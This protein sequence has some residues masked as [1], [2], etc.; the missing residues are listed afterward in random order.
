MLQKSIAYFQ[1][2]IIKRLSEPNK[3]SFWTA[4]CWTFLIFYLSF[5]VPSGVP[6]F[7][8]PYAD[9]I[10]HFGFYFGFVFLWYRYLYYRKM[11]K[12][13]FKMWL[14]LLS[15]SLGIFIEIAQGMFT[16]NRQ[17]D[18]FDALSNTFGSVLGLI[19]VSQLMKQ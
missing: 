9:K 4:L 17:A 2:K 7:E 1:V 15:V 5:K 16:L 12:S 14:L 18:F 8:L 19:T 13:N 6:K 11:I 10:V 3:L